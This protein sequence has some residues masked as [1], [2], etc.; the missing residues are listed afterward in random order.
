MGGPDWLTDTKG[1]DFL[2]AGDV[3][4]PAAKGADEVGVG[5]SEFAKGAVE[6]PERNLAAYASHRS[7]NPCVCMCVRVC[8]VCVRVHT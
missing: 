7:C 1:T 4:T 6:S 2:S 8:G 3:P 5:G